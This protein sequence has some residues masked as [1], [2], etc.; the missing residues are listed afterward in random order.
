MYV[1]KKEILSKVNLNDQSVTKLLKVPSDEITMDSL[2]NKIAYVKHEKTERHIYIRT[3]SNGNEIKAD[4]WSSQNFGPEISPDGAN[5]LFNCMGP[6]T[7]WK[8]CLYNV[9]ADKLE[10]FPNEETK[11]FDY[12][13]NGWKND[14]IASLYTSGSLRLYN[15]LNKLFLREKVFEDTSD[16]SYSMPGSK[17]IEVDNEN[18]YLINGV[19]LNSDTKSCDGPCDNLF[20]VDSLNKVTTLY[21]KYIQVSNAYLTGGVVYSN[22]YN[23]KTS[24]EEMYGITLKTKKKFKMNISG[25]IINVY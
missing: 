13:I 12:G 22:I 14:S 16:Y 25:K 7:T 20:L 1:V 8:I 24:K 17:I 11:S 18:S 9:G 10:A 21:P 15:A 3:I 4:K 23:C 2:E 5:V 6:G 19:N